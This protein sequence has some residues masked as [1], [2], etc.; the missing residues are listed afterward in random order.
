MR[1]VH[2]EASFLEALDSA[3]REALKAFGDDNVLV[4]KYIQK[5]RHIEVQVFGDSFGNAVSLWERDCSVQVSAI[6]STLYSDEP[7]PFDR[8]D[9][10]RSSRRQVKC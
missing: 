10:R 9:T 8:D 6:V 1:I 2:E 3:R 7:T 4:E 5:P